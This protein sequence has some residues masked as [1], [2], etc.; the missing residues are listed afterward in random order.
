MTP[1]SLVL[2]ASTLAAVAVIPGPSISTLVARVLA[3][4]PGEVLPFIAGMLLGEAVWITCTVWGLTAL[5]HSF[6]WAFATLKWAGAGYLLWLAWKMWH[7]PDQVPE[8]RLPDRAPPLRMAATG[9]AVTLGNPKIM[10]FYI[11]LVPTLIDLAHL[12]LGG[13]AEMT[14]TA[15]AVL[16]VIYI[17]WVALATR[18]RRMLKSPRA[19]RLTYRIGAGV[20]AGAAGLIATR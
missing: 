16:A 2:F 7:A 5:A 19:V 8:G 12:G 9:I 3:R 11:A 18:A 17:G 1:A 6:Q 14:V 20:M 13:W 15:I 10:I 4:G